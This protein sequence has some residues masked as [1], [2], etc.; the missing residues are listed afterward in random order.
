MVRPFDRGSGS[1]KVCDRWF[2]E[3]Q[4]AEAVAAPEEQLDCLCLHV[5]LSYGTG[6]V[7]S[8]LLI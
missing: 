2:A 8:T 3:R 5:Y 7:P 6:G 1:C 4:Q